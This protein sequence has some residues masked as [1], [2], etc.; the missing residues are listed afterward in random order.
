ML[1]ESA[2]ATAADVA[3]VL[4]T[5]ADVVPW[6]GCPRAGARSGDPDQ[7]HAPVLDGFEGGVRAAS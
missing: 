7:A 3:P 2:L 1:A 5:A 4:A 6:S